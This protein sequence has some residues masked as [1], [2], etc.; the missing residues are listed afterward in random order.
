VKLHQ[1]SEKGRCSRQWIPVAAVR[2]TSIADVNSHTPTATARRPAMWT[3]N[4]A[5]ALATIP[6]PITEANQFGPRWRKNGLGP[7][8]VA[9]G[10]A[11]S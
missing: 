9:W 2:A 1:V 11:Y 10:V 3:G 6:V 4:S 8:P 7:A 5:A